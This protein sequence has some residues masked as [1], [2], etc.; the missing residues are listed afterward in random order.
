MGEE[1]KSGKRKRRIKEG[2]CAEREGCEERGRREVV[3]VERDV[4]GEREEVWKQMMEM[5]GVFEG[6]C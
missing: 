1:R 4:E 5:K 3:C 2:V 6:M